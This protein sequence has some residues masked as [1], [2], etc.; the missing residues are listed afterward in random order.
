M[1]ITQEFEV[2]QPI[3]KVWTAFQ[4]V[5]SMAQ[6]LPGAELTESK[7]N[8]VYLGTVSVKLGPM[9]PTFE[10]EATVTANEAT[11]TGVIEG[12]GADKKGGSRG[13]VSVTYTLVEKGEN[14]DVS[15]VAEVALSGA[16]A[17]FGRTGV[18]TEV[19]SRLIGEFATCLEAKLSA[20]TAAESANIQAAEVD[21]LGLVASSIASSGKSL[22]GRLFGKKS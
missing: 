16:A 3:E 21:G 15:I 5:P 9:S 10:G 20:G 19:S 17:Q 12:K 8:D 14:T 18:M 22:V 1:E 13:Q 2:A 7:G 6:C 4:D 11:R